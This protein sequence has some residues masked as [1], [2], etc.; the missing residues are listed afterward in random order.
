MSFSITEGALLS[1]VGAVQQQRWGAVW[2]GISSHVGEGSDVFRVLA[3]AGVQREEDLTAIVEA[4]IAI[5]QSGRAV[6]VARHLVSLLPPEMSPPALWA[7]HLLALCLR[8][9][10]D[11]AEALSLWGELAEALSL[12][13]LQHDTAFPSGIPQ[14]KDEGEPLIALYPPIL[15]ALAVTLSRCG[16]H[17]NARLYFLRL[18]DCTKARAQAQYA[19]GMACARAG[20]LEEAAAY[21]S[22]AQEDPDWRQSSWLALGW[23][24]R[25]RGDL[26]E[27]EACYRRCLEPP[28]PQQNEARWGLASVLLLMGRF[29]EG[30]SAFESRFQRGR[31]LLQNRPQLPVYQTCSPIP[32]ELKGKKVLVALEQGLGDAIQMV[33]FAKT[34]AQAG[35]EV[36]WETVPA[37]FSILSTAAGVAEIVP[38]GQ[39]PENL[40]YLVP[41]MSLPHRLCVTPESLRAML[42]GSYLA[43]PLGEPVPWKEVTQ[44]AP[45]RI[46]LVWQGNRAHE[47]DANRSL[48]VSVV[49]HLARSIA[50][51]L[52]NVAL[53]SLQYGGQDEGVERARQE[54]APFLAEDFADWLAAAK[55]DW[56]ATARVIAGLDGVVA[57]DTGVLHLAAAMGK[58]TFALLPFAPDW[59]W[60][61]QGEESLWYP[62]VTLIRQPQIGDWSSVISGLC[63]KLREQWV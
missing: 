9:G 42:D 34:L 57:V 32:S 5:G 55:G 37:L 38:V 62:T 49:C 46:G 2:E 58:Q 40:D 12:V 52:P 53:V 30:F 20:E 11:L 51:T 56:G 35:A 22:A 47:D 14:K 61:M 13:I 60:G 54:L 6:S 63:K 45:C 29:S 10:G 16:Q 23:V 59:R 26:G 27:S 19:Y 3:C 39:T 28:S 21:L 8:D 41:M 1:V 36:Y 33:R 4:A 44:R 43:P 50:Q 25:R 17:E 48:S 24:H 18:L 7:R 15:L 31:A